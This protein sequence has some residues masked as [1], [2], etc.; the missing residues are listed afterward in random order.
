MS[1]VRTLALGIALAA[2]P[3]AGT[4]LAEEHSLESMLVEWAT[5]PAQHQA[6]AKHFKAKADEAR[7]DAAQHRAMAKSYSSTKAANVKA[8]VE[9]CNELAALSDKTAAEYDKLAAGE[10][11]VK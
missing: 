11:A 1:F 3:L 5:T 10:E 2:V 9:H 6:L 8:Q 4:A 7:A